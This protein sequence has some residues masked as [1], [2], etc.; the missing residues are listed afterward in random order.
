LKDNGYLEE[1]N[2]ITLSEEKLDNNKN[3][4]IFTPERFM[5]FLDKNKSLY[6]DFL[7]FDEIYKIDNDFCVEIDEDI[8]ESENSRDIAFRISLELGIRK[9]NDIV[10]AGPFLE[11]NSITMNNF[12]RDNFIETLDFNDIE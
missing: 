5:T 9:S 12:V 2:I 4:L 7:F 1:H 10:L 8:V 3:I 6:F 11:Y